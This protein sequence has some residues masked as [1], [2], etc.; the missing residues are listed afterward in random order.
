MSKNGT[1]AERLSELIAQKNEHQAAIRQI[2]ETAK[3]LR[4]TLAKEHC[5]RLYELLRE[6][7]NEFSAG[8]I[9][10]LFDAVHTELLGLQENDGD[11]VR[12]LSAKDNPYGVSIEGTGAFYLALLDQALKPHMSMDK[13]FAWIFARKGGDPA[14]PFLARG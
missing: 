7:S 10:G 3:A 11:Y 1:T 12:T 9:K 14:N 6:L 4:H 2:T 5:N 8:R 13:V